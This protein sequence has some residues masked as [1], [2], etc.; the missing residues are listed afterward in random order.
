[1]IDAGL[2]T[3]FGFALNLVVLAVGGTW[4]LTRVEAS[5][6]AT[7]TKHKEEA[8][9]KLIEL[10]RSWENRT[11]ESERRF[12]EVGT[13]LRQKIHE[14]ETW[15]RDQF[16]RK[17]SFNE[18]I[19][20]VEKTLDENNKRMETRLMRIENKIDRAPQRSGDSD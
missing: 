1:M 8:D 19:S 18:G 3:V 9:E 6:N 14:I 7:I 20:R 10:E 2:I 15:S 16:M 4:K 13:A 17:E 5:I 11:V 12:G